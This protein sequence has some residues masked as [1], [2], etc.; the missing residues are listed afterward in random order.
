MYI[1]VCVYSNLKILKLWKVSGSFLASF[2]MR[3]RNWEVSR[4]LKHQGYLYPEGTYQWHNNLYPG[5]MSV[6]CPEGSQ[7]PRPIEGEE[8]CRRTLPLSWSPGFYILRYDWTRFRSSSSTSTTIGICWES[9]LGT[10][11][12][13]KKKGRKRK[14]DFSGRL[15][16][17]EALLWEDS[18][19]TSLDLHPE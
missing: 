16:F 14:A 10:F 12:M 3:S 6:L 4:I 17:L 9:C 13:E 18:E 2:C 1:S 19:E 11:A 7:G 8:F 15:W 5:S